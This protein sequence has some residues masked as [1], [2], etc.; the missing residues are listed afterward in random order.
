MQRRPCDRCP[1]EIWLEILSQ[2]IFVPP[3]RSIRSPILPSQHVESRERRALSQISRY[4]R[5]LVCGW[6]PFWNSIVVDS[7]FVYNVP[8]RHLQNTVV[9]CTPGQIDIEI[10][11]PPIVGDRG[12]GTETEFRRLCRFIN[13]E[14]ILEKCRTIAY[15]G[16]ADHCSELFRSQAILP[17]VTKIYLAISEWADPP[18]VFNFH[19]FPSLLYLHCECSRFDG[20]LALRLHQPLSSAT[21]RHLSLPIGMCIADVIPILNQLPHLQHLEC[22]LTSIR[23]KKQLG[24]LT[25]LSLPSLQ[26]LSFSINSTFPAIGFLRL[27]SLTI[28]RLSDGCMWSDG[29]DQLPSPPLQTAFPSLRSFILASRS[30]SSMMSTALSRQQGTPPRSQADRMAYWARLFNGLPK[31][32]QR[33]AFNAHRNGGI[34]ELLVERSYSGLRF[35]PDLEEL[36]IGIPAEQISELREEVAG[37]LLSRKHLAINSWGSECCNSLRGFW[38]D[39]SGRERAHMFS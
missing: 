9:R 29:L 1:A 2:N 11:Q 25:T 15:V 5:E 23:T 6:A 36:D 14:R 7:G 35:F 28:L 17:S 39:E 19:L 16:T 4:F 10:H 22:E 31:Q 3:L 38:K 24:L 12:F 13:D 30:R 27:P 26:S 34:E 18:H 20:T 21:I 32:L 33:L 8:T 37:K